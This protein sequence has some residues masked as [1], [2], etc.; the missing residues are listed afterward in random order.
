MTE[1]CP[2]SQSSGPVFRA[3]LPKRKR[4]AVVTAGRSW[5]R[6]GN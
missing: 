3:N 6:C 2:T 5:K 1:L 4:P